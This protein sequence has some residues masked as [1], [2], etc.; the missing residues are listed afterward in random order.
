MLT[1]TNPFLL[2]L[3]D[4]ELKDFIYNSGGR[5]LFSLL[6]DEWNKLNETNKICGKDT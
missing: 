2:Y 3:E 1:A 6:Y 4:R 5:D